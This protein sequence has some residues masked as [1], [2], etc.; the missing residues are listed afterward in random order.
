METFGAHVGKKDADLQRLLSDHRHLRSLL[1]EGSLESLAAFA[2]ELDDHIRFEENLLFP[3]MEKTLTEAEKKA[4]A[5]LLE[6][7]LP[8]GPA[9][10]RQ[11]TTLEA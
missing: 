3:R 9:L 1:K 7:T 11:E 8:A 2:T 10:N 4:A 6:K 5:L